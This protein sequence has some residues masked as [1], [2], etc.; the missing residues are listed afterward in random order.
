V[1]GSLLVE[2]PGCACRAGRIRGQSVPRTGADG[3]EVLIVRITIVGRGN[4]GGG[5]ARLWTAAGHETTALGREGGD[6]SDCEVVV[7]AVPGGSIA[8]ALSK[9]TGIAGKPTIDATNSFTGPRAGFDSLAQ[10][11][12]SIIG[13]PTA[14]CF[15]TNFAAL[16]DKVA[17]EVPPPTNVFAAD[18]AARPIAERLVRDAGYEPLF[19]GGLQNAPT[20]EAHIRFTMMIAGSDFGPY[21]YRIT[22][23][24]P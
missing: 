22:K 14:K 23:P 7:V 10:E 13:G 20:L 3:Q 9:V 8:E 11:V 18:P 24:G 21:F 19:V 6:G 17:G 16:Y 2:P 4:V 15:N 5:L 12:Q 1:N